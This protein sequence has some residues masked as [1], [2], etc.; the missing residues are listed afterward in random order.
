MQQFVATPLWSRPQ[1]VKSWEYYLGG[2]AA[3][4]YAAPAR[5]PELV[6]ALVDNPRQADVEVTYY[7]SLD[8][9]LSRTVPFEVTAP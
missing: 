3:D 4:H 9:F 8:R 5:T 2:R 1:A 6:R 7:G